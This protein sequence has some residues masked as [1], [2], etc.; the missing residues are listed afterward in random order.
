MLKTAAAKQWGVEPATVQTEN[1]V[2]SA[3]SQKVS[4]I[5]IINNTTDWEIPETPELR[6]RSSFKIVG[7]EQRRPDLEPKVKGEPLFALDYEL[8]NML[9][10]NLLKCPYINGDLVEMDIAAAKV[11]P[12]VVD[13][14]QEMNGDDEVIAVVAENRYAAEMGKRSL[15]AQ[16]DFSQVWQQTD[17]DNL[18]TVGAPNTSP[19]NLQREGRVVRILNADGDKL[20][21]AEYRVATGVHAHMEPNSAIADVQ[22]IRLL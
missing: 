12:G 14:F 19:T 16:W 10:A 17:I 21:S 3:G 4:Y 6:P 22:G 7:T 20:V 9:Y 8:P 18:T 1:G 2:L 15:N 5:D 11:V 13:V